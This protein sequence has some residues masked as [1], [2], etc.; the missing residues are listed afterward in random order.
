VPEIH[1]PH[2]CPFLSLLT[3]PS[4]P[5]TPQLHFSFSCWHGMD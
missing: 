3:F 2:P 4:S 1:S 5:L